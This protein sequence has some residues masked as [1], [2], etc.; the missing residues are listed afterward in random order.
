MPANTNFLLGYGETLTEPVTQPP[1]KAEKHPP[2]SFFEAKSRVLPMIQAAAREIRSLPPR[3]CPGD[4]AVAVL[5]LHPEYLAKSYFPLALLQSLRLDSVG[6]RPTV[7]K[8]EK[9]SRQGEPT[10]TDSTDLFIAGPRDAFIGWAS[11]LPHWTEQ[12]VGADDLVAIEQFRS[13]R[14]KDRIQ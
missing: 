10:A 8:P 1:K 11:G 7:V 13:Q 3:A 14:P 6:S 9:W 4:Q 12:I 2:Y 5:T